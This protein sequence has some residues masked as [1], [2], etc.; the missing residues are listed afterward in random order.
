V[1]G[2]FRAKPVDPDRLDSAE[3]VFSGL[4]CDPERI[5]DV[6]YHLLDELSQRSAWRRQSNQ[7][8]AATNN[9][10]DQEGRTVPSDYRHY[11]DRPLEAKDDIKLT[12]DMFKRD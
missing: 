9:W 4:L 1:E 12:T 11:K 5:N 3:R 10:R 7:A 2:V 6:S 8:A